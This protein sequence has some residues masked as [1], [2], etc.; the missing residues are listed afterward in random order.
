MNLQAGTMQMRHVL[1]ALLL[2]MGYGYLAAQCLEEAYYLP[3]S[4][5]ELSP[6]KIIVCRFADR[7]LLTQVLT[8]LKLEI[9]KGSGVCSTQANDQQ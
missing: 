4:S 3:D 9:D 6:R 1:D 2:V 7:A 5:N 8:Q